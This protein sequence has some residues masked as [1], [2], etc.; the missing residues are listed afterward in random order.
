MYF[1]EIFKEPFPLSYYIQSL[2]F[3]TTSQV[4]ND[5][6]HDFIKHS[7]L[8]VHSFQCNKYKQKLSKSHSRYEGNSWKV[9]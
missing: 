2:S 4:C 5:Y 3:T 7:I 8:N 1:K 9:R 6:C